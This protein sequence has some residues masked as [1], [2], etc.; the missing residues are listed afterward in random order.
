MLRDLLDDGLIITIYDYDENSKDDNIG[1]ALIDL[2]PLFCKREGT[3]SGH[4][5]SLQ[6]YV[7]VKVIWQ[8]AAGAWEQARTAALATARPGPIEAPAL[9]TYGVLSVRLHSAEGLMA[10]D[11]NGYSDPYVKLH[12]G[13]RK[14]ERSDVCEM[15][16]DPLWDQTFRFSGI[17]SA[18]L[19]EPLKLVLFDRDKK[20]GDADD[21]LG[22]ATFELS[23]LRTAYT[24]CLSQSV[25]Y[26]RTVPRGKVNL[27]VSWTTDDLERGDRLSEQGGDEAIEISQ[28][29][30]VGEI[31]VVLR[32][33]VGLVP[34]TSRGRCDPFVRLEL[35]D[36]EDGKPHKLRSRHLKK[37]TSPQW[38]QT[39]VLRGVKRRLLLEPLRLA[40]F[41]Y[42]GM[43]SSSQELGAAQLDVS[44]LLRAARASY[45]AKLTYG[46]S[47]AS[48]NIA[49]AI[50]LDVEWVS[51]TAP[52][53][54]TSMMPGPALRLPGHE[55]R[56]SA[57]T[58]EEGTQPASILRV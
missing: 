5:L 4:E 56:L 13:N 11:R 50:E 57:P 44:A 49:G 21:K 17:I 34:V 40:V 54:L 14:M 39:L 15:T 58:A 47:V 46:R 3:F 52:L 55:S 16:L 33:A 2:E 28:L 6:G 9:G 1:M 53:T 36:P 51:S 27:I 48:S 38:N 42:E 26:K 10:A 29:N 37:T 7:S 25:M 22:E 20:I 19:D 43:L 45:S 30:E 35:V 41:D 32:K 23:G 24:V 31:R 18:M 12:L 8:S